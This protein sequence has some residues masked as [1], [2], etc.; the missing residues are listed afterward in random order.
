M[1]N[2]L[3]D[4]LGEVEG[5]VAEVEEHDRDIRQRVI[6]LSEQLA[7]F[8][9]RAAA[10]A[11][12]KQFTIED[13]YE[14]ER[15]YGYLG[16]S[17]QG[18]YLGHRST[19]EDLYDEMN[20]A[21]AEAQGYHVS[22]PATWDTRWLRV[23]ATDEH[24]RDL[25]SALQKKL[26]EIKQ[27]RASVADAVGQLSRNPPPAVEQ[28]LLAAAREFNFDWLNREWGKAQRDLAVDPTR[29][30][31]AASSLVESTL[32]HI[33]SHRG[34][35]LPADQSIQVL[36]K[37]VAKDL[38][39]LSDENASDAV[40]GMTRALA[41]LVQNIGAFRTKAG[42]AHGRGPNDRVATLSAAQLAVTSAGACCSYL[43]RRLRE[44]ETG[45]AI[46]TPL[47]NSKAST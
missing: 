10:S 6:A 29:A 36:Y 19:L 23:A 46:E 20:H 35:D 5:L 15:V 47:E 45:D 32:K 27:G 17:T 1:A 9:K 26:A 39:P 7:D 42:D 8:C 31:T 40:R 30:I 16:V 41:S 43:L 25:L 21:P 24:I 13:R 3:S 34:R 18:I 11:I 14:N 44:L 4:I 28:A 33:I 38:A 37:N 2:G 12:G 22:S